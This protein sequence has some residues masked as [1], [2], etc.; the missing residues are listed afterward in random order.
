MQTST[1]MWLVAIILVGI[2]V[3]FTASQVLAIV[4]GVLILIAALAQ[5]GIL[6]SFWAKITGKP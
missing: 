4:W 5:T 6:G 3:W 2:G 1:V